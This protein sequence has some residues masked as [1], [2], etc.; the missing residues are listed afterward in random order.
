[1]NIALT[2][3][4]T[5][6]VVLLE[7]G[8]TPVSGETAAVRIE[9][10]E[11]GSDLP[12][13]L[14]PAGTGTV[15]KIYSNEEYVV[16]AASESVCVS[17]VASAMDFSSEDFSFYGFGELDATPDIG[18]VSAGCDGEDGEYILCEGVAYDSLYITV[19]CCPSAVFEER[20]QRIRC[21]AQES[22]TIR[23]GRFICMFTQKYRI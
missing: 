6:S 1:M 14:I 17:T 7:R 3:I 18:V 23:S 13:C 8:V 5:G 9:Q 21:S 16:D 15:E 22:R 19:T 20:K 4:D 12:S 10:L 11:Y 2:G